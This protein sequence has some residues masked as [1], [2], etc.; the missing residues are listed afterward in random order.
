[1]KTTH[2]ADQDESVNRSICISRGSSNSGRAGE[3]AA[4]WGR[5][6]QAGG[7]VSRMQRRSQRTDIMRSTRL[8]VVTSPPCSRHNDAPTTDHSPCTLR[9]RRYTS[10]ITSQATTQIISPTN[11]PRRQFTPIADIPSRQRLPSS[12]SDDLLVP[13]VRLPTIGR[14]AFL[15][16]GARTW[17]ELLVHVTSAPSL[18]TFRKRLKLH[19]FRL[20][21]PGLV[22]YINR[23]SVWSLW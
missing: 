21:Y 7:A 16:A 13:A 14:R 9:R 23:F 4:G 1:M 17:N 2:D 22:S 8:A 11:L 6:R 18:F 12:S 10:L 19:L 3:G 20:S 15:V 5:W